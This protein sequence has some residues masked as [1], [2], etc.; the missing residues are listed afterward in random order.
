MPLGIGAIWDR[1]QKGDSQA[2][3]TCAAITTAANRLVQP[4]NDRMPVIVAETDYDDWL[5]QAFFDLEEL[6]RMM[7]PFPE[8][9]M[10]L[11]PSRLV[12]G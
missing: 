5:D 4:V 12:T 1:W 3:E 10:E 2:W 7:R 11:V 6:E 8:D 9:E